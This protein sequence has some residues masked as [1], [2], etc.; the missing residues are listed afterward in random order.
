MNPEEPMP[1]IPMSIK[2]DVPPRRDPLS[3]KE[4]R[5]NLSGV[6]ALECEYQRENKFIPQPHQT[7]AVRIY[8]KLIK[9]QKHY[10]I[11]IIKQ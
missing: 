1:E 3:I 5:D 7:K 2:A 4:A 6:C 10:N 8:Q 11:Y 9:S